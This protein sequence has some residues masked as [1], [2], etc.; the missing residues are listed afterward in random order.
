M[1]KT[2]IV[3]GA[4]SGIGRATAITF[5]R[6]GA[7][8]IV[9]DLVSGACEETARL[10]ADSGG[11]AFAIS[12][13]VCDPASIENLVAAAVARY[14]ALHFAV[15][16]AGITGPAVPAADVTESQWSR[17]IAVNLTGVWLCMKH[18]IPAILE[19]GGGAIVNIASTAGLRA[20]PRT[21]PYAASKHGVVGLTRAAALDYA[22]AGVRVNAVC[23]G[24]I[25]TPMLE[26]ITQG[27]EEIDS[28]IVGSVAMGRAGTPEEVAETVLWLCSDAASFVT[29]QAIA[30]DGGG[31]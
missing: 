13:D 27:R 7:A 11:E 2:V 31:R 19:A 14:G 18:E 30:V 26:R 12:A 8:V 16:S 29:G 9:A 3:T 17:V 15:N 25:R 10:I 24:P 28:Q 22:T 23:P 21:A 20:G 4:A 5:A 6:A 1:G